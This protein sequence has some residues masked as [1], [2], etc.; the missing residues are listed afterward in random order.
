M[1]KE[2]KIE[3]EV[4]ASEPVKSNLQIFK[5]SLVKTCLSSTSHGIP[6][7]FRNEKWTLKIFWTI[8]FLLAA[9]GAVYC[10]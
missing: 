4:E 3:E 10:E 7:I 1:K 6:S 8:L 2:K 9:G 5:E